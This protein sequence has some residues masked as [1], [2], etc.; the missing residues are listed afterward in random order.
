MNPISP[1]VQELQKLLGARN[2]L[3]QPDDLRVY[4]YD[5][6]NNMATPDL[7]V[8][9]ES[10]EQVSEIIK[11]ARR[12]SMAI[13]PRGSGTGLCGAVTPIAGGIMI[14]FARMKKIHN[15]DLENRTA[16][17]EP[18][19]I[20]LDVSAALAPYRYFY[21][22]DPSSQAACSIGGNV[23]NNSGGPHCLLYGVTANHVLGLEVVLEDGEIL[24]LG[25]SAPDEQGYDL[26]A[27]FIAAR[28]TSK[29]TIWSPRSLAAKARSASLPKFSFA[30]CPC[31]KQRARSSP[32]STP[33]SKHRALSAASSA[34][35]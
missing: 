30:S 21:A 18:G 8:L 23:A 3:W 26:V 24:W 28:P 33:S 4:S 9:P 15:I 7:V 19:V 34:R 35:A 31:P 29:D 32:F 11:L 10:A 6:S 17:V 13:V 1:A 22:P 25:G 20:N 16:L 12:Y 14:A 27:A 2:V 5:G